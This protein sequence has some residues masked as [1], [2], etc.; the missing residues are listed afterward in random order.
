MFLYYDTVCF[1]VYGE[2]IIIPYL[3]H[4]FG[5]KGLENLLEQGAIKFL[6]SNTIITHLES[7]IK[8]IYPLQSGELSSAAHKNP[9]DSL[10]LGFTF[11]INQ[12]DR[13]KRKNLT[14][15]ILKNYNI[16]PKNISSRIVDS[17]YQGYKDNI[18]S[19]LGLPYIKS[20]EDFKI[21]ESKKMAKIAEHYLDLSLMAYYQYSS[22]D[23]YPLELLNTEQIKHLKNIKKIKEYTDKTFN[24]EKIPNF[25]MLINTGRLKKEDIPEF[26]KNKHSIKFRKW[27][28]SLSQQDFETF[29]VK[30]YLD[31]IEGN[32]TF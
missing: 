10:A 16:H 32:K 29:D 30:E 24:F 7:P 6:L 12:L 1:D 9:E 28:A 5:E 25:E 22:I 21:E 27:I 14:K 20:L 2:N 17:V 4:L 8:G 11:S 15:K 3:I 13:K 19:T 23:S 31:S 26:R 18:F